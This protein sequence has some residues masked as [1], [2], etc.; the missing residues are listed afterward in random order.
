MLLVAACGVLVWALAPF[1]CWCGL[2]CVGRYANLAGGFA[3][4]L[5]A[6]WVL[7][8]LVFYAATLAVSCTA[9]TWLA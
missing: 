2:A 8:L 6:F 3:F 7:W 1:C 4:R 9:V 5:L